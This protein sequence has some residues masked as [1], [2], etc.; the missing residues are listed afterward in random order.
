[1][2]YVYVTTVGDTGVRK[3]ISVVC[4][5]RKYEK[6][7]LSTSQRSYGPREPLDIWRIYETYKRIWCG[8]SRM[9]PTSWLFAVWFNQEYVQGCYTREQ[10]LPVVRREKGEKRGCWY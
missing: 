9:K 3:R 2:E 5:E 8:G 6:E 1:V 4:V 7:E 10:R